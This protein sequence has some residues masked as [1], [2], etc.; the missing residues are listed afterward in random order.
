[1]ICSIFV[2][3]SVDGEDNFKTN[4]VEYVRTNKLE[5]LYSNDE[6]ALAYN[7]AEKI[8]EK[9][10]ND[11]F[12]GFA[13][14]IDYPVKINNYNGKNIIVKNKRKFLKLNKKIIFNEHLKQA[15]LKK[16]IFD[17]YMGFML[18]DG[19]IWFYPF[20]QDEWKIICINIIN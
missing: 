14:L 3:Q 2:F 20:R 17:N 15:V 12:S 4:S 13:D 5:S 8:Q 18:G 16:E 1:M 11:D 7:F 9:V 10:S 6:L 19:D